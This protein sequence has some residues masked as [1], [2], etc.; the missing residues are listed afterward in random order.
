MDCSNWKIYYKKTKKITI[1]RRTVVKAIELFRDRKTLNDSQFAIDLGCG[2][3]IDSIELL[4]NKWSVLAIDSQANAIS[5][6][7]NSCPQ[8]LKSKL[9]TKIATFETISHLPLCQ[10]INASFSLPFLKREF[11]YPFWNIILNTLPPKGLFSGTFFGVKDDWYSN[12]DLDMTFLTRKEFDNLFLPFKILWF[13]EKEHY[14]VDASGS[15]LKYWH[16]YLVV[17][18]KI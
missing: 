9:A 2:A 3:G 16:Q 7:L 12:K 4:R 18:E 5:T 6:L 17:A 11:F 10:L 13:D 14:G 8:S 1:P 15:Y